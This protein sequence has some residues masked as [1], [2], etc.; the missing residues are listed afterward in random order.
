L[1]HYS[2]VAANSCKV[3]LDTASLF[4]KDLEWLSEKSFYIFSL[5]IRGCRVKLN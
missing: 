5:M 3:V 2:F 1:H 4:S